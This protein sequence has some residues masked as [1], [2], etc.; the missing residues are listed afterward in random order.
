[1]MYTAKKQIE[2][3]D[4]SVSSNNLKKSNLKKQLSNG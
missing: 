3:F 4:A 2:E 1:M